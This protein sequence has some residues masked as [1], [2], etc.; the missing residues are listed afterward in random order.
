VPGY[1]S[2]R[3]FLVYW[4]ATGFGAAVLTL[5]LYL[6]ILIYTGPAKLFT[7][8]FVSPIPWPDFIETISH[9]L[10]ETWGE[11]TFRVPLI[12]VLLLTAGWTS[13]LLFHK[14][15]SSTRIPLQAAAALWILLLLLVQRPNAWSKVWVFIQPLMLLWAAAGIIGLLGLIR[16]RTFPLAAIAVGL[17]MGWGIWHAA[18]LAS[19]LPEL[20]KIQG[21]EESAVLFAQEQLVD[22][23]EIV[24]APP[25]DAP[26]W[27]Y[28]ELH[29]AYDAL[30]RSDSAF[31]RLF[32]LVNPAEGQTPE[33]VIDSRGP[34]V[35]SVALESCRLMNTFGK[36][37]VFE[38]LHK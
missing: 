15:I 32:V 22:G 20:W 6:P 19:E 38:C 1:A 35:A 28:A 29:G 12:V 24:V 7:N 34:G 37:Q 5:M 11:W 10:L 9:R 21:S 18:N 16:I 25:D 26:V 23:D 17:F 31:N 13:S 3:D 2:R 4:L 8:G 14:K 27:Y 36:M 33:T 30:Y